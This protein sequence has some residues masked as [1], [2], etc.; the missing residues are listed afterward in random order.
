[1][2][3][4]WQTEWFGIKFSEFT[5]PNPDTIAD[6]EFYERFY[7]RF[8][9]KFDSYESLPQKYRQNKTGIAKDLLRFAYHYD[10]MMSIGCGN[11]IIEHYIVNHSDKAI[12]AIEPSNNSKWLQNEKQIK[13]VSGFFP[14]AVRDEKK[15]RFGYC[16]SIDYVFDDRQYLEFLSAVKSYGFEEFYFTEVI[17]PSKKLRNRLAYYIK[18]GLY[19]LGLYT[20]KGQFW[21]YSRTI[22]EHETFL[23][24][25]GFK[26]IQYGKHD[27]GN[28]WIRVINE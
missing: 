25:A 19:K 17:V 11:G 20:Y 22:K 23:K 15:Y 14:A 3:K 4:L 16:S 12:L 6:E 13:F 24:K 2:K 27:H 10:A 8:Y 5:T 1:M 26:N 28:Y 9:E 18:A 21:G 7:E